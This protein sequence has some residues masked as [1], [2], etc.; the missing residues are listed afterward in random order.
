[1]KN[2]TP[3]LPVLVTPGAVLIGFGHQNIRNQ[4]NGEGIGGL[5][6]SIHCL[7]PMSCWNRAVVWGGDE[8]K[9][10]V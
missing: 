7:S 1:M 10:N 8:G 6:M 2:V 3:M 4:S 9:L 5:S